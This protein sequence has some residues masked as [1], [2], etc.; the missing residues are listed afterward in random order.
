MTVRGSCLCGA[1]GYEILG[2]P[3][4]VFHCHCSRCRK[5]RGTA[6]ATNMALRPDA[7]RYV[8]GEDRLS[9]YKPP[10]ADRFT[11]VFC[12]TCGSSMPF[13]SPYRPIVVLP[14]GS[15]DDPPPPFSAEHI[16]VAS[17]ASWD[18]ITDSLPQHPEGPNR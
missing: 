14:M 4:G 11:H 8:R 5:A 9:S 16:F 10:D 6:H 1:V 13:V 15:L 3:I 12:S 2:P 7:F 18:V 17:K